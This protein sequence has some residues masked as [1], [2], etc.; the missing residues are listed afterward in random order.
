MKKVLSFLVVFTL[1]FAM[2]PLNPTFGAIDGDEDY[3]AIEVLDGLGVTISEI[4]VLR[5]ILVDFYVVEGGTDFEAGVDTFITDVRGENTVIGD[6]LDSNGITKEKVKTD[7]NALKDLSLSDLSSIT[8]YLSGL[9]NNGPYDVLATNLGSSYSSNMPTYLYYLG[10]R[11]QNSKIMEFDDNGDTLTFDFDN[12]LYNT[13]PVSSYTGGTS[14]DLD[15]Y[16]KL[17]FN[18]G[19]NTEELDNLDVELRASLNTKLDNYLTNGSYTAKD[20]ANALNAVGLVEMMDSTPTPDDGDTND[21]DTDD[22]DTGGG[23]NGGGS[24]GGGTSSDEED[25]I[26]DKTFVQDSEDFQ[27]KLNDPDATPEEILEAVQQVIKTA[28]SLIDGEDISNEEATALVKKV[29]EETINE[30][31][32]SEKTSQKNKDRLKKFAR[33]LAKR[34]ARKAGTVNITAQ[35]EITKAL[36]EEAIIKAKEAV[37]SLEDILTNL[38]L[39]NSNKPMKA[40]VILKSNDEDSEISLS[41]EVIEALKGQNVDLVLATKGSSIIIPS[42]MLDTIEEGE[43]IE[44]SSK[45]MS[46]VLNDG[47]NDQAGEKYTFVKT[48][49]IT[50]SKKKADGTSE[51]LTR[52]SMDFDLSDYEGNTDQV[53]VLVRNN[54]TG[55][56]ELLMS[57]VIDGKVEFKSPHYSYYTLAKYTPDFSDVPGHWA[58]SVINKMAAKGIVRGRSDEIFDP[59]GDIARAEFITMLMNAFDYEATIS[60]PFDDTNSTDWYFVPV[61]SGKALGLVNGVGQNQF[62]P[63]ASITRQD[64]VV[65]MARFYEE[66]RGE[67]LAG[68][69]NFFND[70]DKASAYARYYIN[71]AAEVEIVIGDG[72][73]FKPLNNATRAEALKMIDNLLIYLK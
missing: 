68:A 34:V 15:S 4:E 37:K 71:G 24:S 72:E 8:S 41:S 55:A 32:T 67:S 56:F 40:T 12:R 59:Q 17:A 42:E 38:D 13:L 50:V 66:E 63:N 70:S 28:S 3:S 29:I 27:E 14:Y 5:D 57:W 1:I 48:R 31:I 39:N 69:V 33:K 2:V 49:D 51:Q 45:V 21:D 64:M 61:N 9:S 60:S 26:N 43:T 58:E 36:V 35:T 11:L 22:G 53:A 16:L 18:M 10:R 23:S 7:A 62:N 46:E 6:I 65:M 19:S 54:E 73:G 30:A 20:I 44:I 25:I 52:L 47:L